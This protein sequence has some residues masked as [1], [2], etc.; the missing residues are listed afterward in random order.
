[1]L[2][3]LK[4]GVVTRKGKT[5]G[6]RLALPDAAGIFS[7]LPGRAFPRHS[8]RSGLRPA[9]QPGPPG[10]R[11][12]SVS[13]RQPGLIPSR[14]TEIKDPFDTSLFLLTT[15]SCL[16]AFRDGNKRMG[17]LLSNVPLP[18]AGM[19]PLSLV[20]IGMHAAISG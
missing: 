11:R 7:R 2:R 15:T 12:T 4:T 6:S 14:A 10:C 1:M 17:R 19:P 18:E 3:L 9:S 16:Q 13:S 8:I 20:D 5:K